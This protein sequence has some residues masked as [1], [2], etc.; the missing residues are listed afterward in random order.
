MIAKFY[1]ITALTNMHV[2][3]G[4]ANQGVIDNLIQ[5]DVVTGLPT[6]NGSSLKGA[7]KEF[8]TS[9]WTDDEDK[10]RLNKIF[11]DNDN[12]A[13]YRFLSADLLALPLRSNQ[14]PYFLAT[15]PSVVDKLK[16]DLQ[17][18]GI[19]NITS[20]VESPING[21]PVVFNTITTNTLIEDF[22]PTRSQT[23][24]P[25]E[26]LFFISETDKTVILSDEDFKT[27]CDDA[28][29]PVIARNNLGENKNLWYEQVLPRESILGFTLLI[30]SD[31]EDADF[32]AFNQLLTDEKSII[33]IGANATVGQGFTKIT[34]IQ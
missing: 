26:A 20:T 27:V 8:F 25:Q 11:G 23:D 6:I 22:T 9:K 14:K 2:G 19:K 21:Q 5:R 16:K 1:T 29:L 3:S 12:A 34:Q 15:A 13:N 32:N 33:H 30:N 31:T 4:D 7:L 28:H 10:R 17:I 24:Y 18:Y